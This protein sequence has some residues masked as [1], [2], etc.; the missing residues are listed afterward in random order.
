MKPQV[1]VITKS[2]SFLITNDGSPIHFYT[3]HGNGGLGKAYHKGRV[4]VVMNGQVRRCVV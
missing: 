2:F 3:A 4:E 1:P